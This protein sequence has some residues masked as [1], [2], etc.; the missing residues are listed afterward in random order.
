MRGYT[1]EGR[2]ASDINRKKQ[3]GF[4]T[5][6]GWM[7]TGLIEESQGKLAFRLRKQATKTVGKV[8]RGLV[9]QAAKLKFGLTSAVPLRPGFVSAV[10]V[11]GLQLQAQLESLGEGLV[12]PG[13]MRVLDDL[14]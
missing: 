12:T 13:K 6:C 4:S 11:L 5:C 9:F 14:S 1:R 7:C 3:Y 10:I 8:S 2:A